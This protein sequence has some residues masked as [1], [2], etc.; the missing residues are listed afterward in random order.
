MTGPEGRDHTL[1]N[2]HWTL[3]GTE[4]YCSCRKEGEDLFLFSPP[5]QHG[6]HTLFY[7]VDMSKLAA[8]CYLE[9]LVCFLDIPAYPS[10]T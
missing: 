2:R 7:V 5:P 1:I 10:K 3:G 6:F 9:V 4:T 8:Y